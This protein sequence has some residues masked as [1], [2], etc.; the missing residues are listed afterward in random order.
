MRCSSWRMVMISL[1]LNL[2]QLPADAD[3]TMDDS[4][5]IDSIAGL[6]KGFDPRSLPL[7][8]DVFKEWDE[9]EEVHLQS[10]Y[11]TGEVFADEKLT[12]TRPFTAAENNSRRSKATS[13]APHSRRWPNGEFGL[14]AVLG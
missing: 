7:D 4:A 10:L 13:R 9:N 6:W 5:A 3:G 1:L 12:R 2:M 11:F 14:A 8:V